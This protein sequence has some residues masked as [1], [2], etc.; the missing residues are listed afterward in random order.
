MS[1]V[2]E[3]LCT[4][5]TGSQAGSS[6]NYID[7][8]SLPGSGHWNEP[9]TAADTTM[10]TRSNSLANCIGIQLTFP[11]GINPYSSYPFM[12]HNNHSLPWDI[13]ILSHQMWVQAIGCKT[14]PSHNQESCQPCRELLHNNIIQGILQRIEI[15]VHESTPMA[16]QP[17]GGLIELVQRKSDSL[18]ALCLTKLTMAWKLIIRARTL[19]AHKKFIMAL[20]DSKVNQLDDLIRVALK[21]N[22]GIHGMIE[23]LDRTSK[24]IYQ[25]H[26]YTEEETLQGLLFQSFS[27]L[28]VCVLLISHTDHLVHQGYQPS[29]Q[30]LPSPCYLPLPEHQQTWRYGQTYR[31]HSRVQILVRIMAMFS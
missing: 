22:L 1:V 19:D 4:S 16:D 13:H 3:I 23:L 11:P 8:D 5:P 18:E 26:S 20:A 15:G 10:V 24:G 12:L 27:D 25:P 31:W 14:L 28:G 6:L 30:A 9:S 21:G 29:I 7:V 2:R 17:I